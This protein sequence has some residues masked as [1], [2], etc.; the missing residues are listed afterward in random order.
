MFE[1]DYTAKTADDE[2]V[3]GRISAQ[4]EAVARASLETRGWTVIA[5]S[6]VQ[7]SGRPS[8]PA[9]L[10]RAEVGELTQTVSDV[11]SNDHQV[12]EGFRAAALETSH[13]RL[14][15]T[16]HAFADQLEAGKSLT[17]LLE[18]QSLPAHLLG[19]VKS[20]ARTGKLGFALTELLECQRATRELKRAVTLDLAYPVVVACLATLV[21]TFMGLYVVPIF[22]EMFLEFG[23]TLP[24]NTLVLLWL[25]A[26]L[27]K[28]FVIIA[29]PLFV[30]LMIFRVMAG[31][32]LWGRVVQSV[33][34]VGAIW[35][36]SAIVDFS[37]TCGV[38][39][40]YDVPLSE[41]ILLTSDSVEDVRMQ[42]MARQLVQALASGESL[43]DSFRRRWYMPPSFVPFIAWGETANSLGESFEALADMYEERVRVRSAL[44]RTMVPPLVFVAVLLVVGWVAFSLFL[45]LLSLISS[46]GF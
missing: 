8:P 25:S 11:C 3:Q 46:L 45:P 44:L 6:R 37:R 26:V 4:D 1:F 43:R 19:L 22:R 32:S 16:F 18:E 17:Q 23:M 10:S 24:W 15:Q 41:A 12:I 2:A 35:K 42:Q 31:D 13:V 29:P 9:R 30:L 14:A 36:W 38:L 34:F 27:V 28:G 5:L 39:L 20:A 33:P 21:F 40:R 7:D